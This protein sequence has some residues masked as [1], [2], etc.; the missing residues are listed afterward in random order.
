MR[1]WVAVDMV[2]SFPWRRWLPLIATAAAALLL[3]AAASAW[4]MRRLSKEVKRRTQAEH[5][6]LENVG[7]LGGSH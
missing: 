2:P 5:G 6:E 1:R 3:L 4:W 7:T